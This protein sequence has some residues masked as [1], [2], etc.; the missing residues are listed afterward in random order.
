MGR[1]LLL[2]LPLLL[3]AACGDRP[4]SAEE[5]TVSEGDPSVPETEPPV[6]ETESAVAETEPAISYVTVFFS[7]GEEAVG[8]R[9]IVEEPP[10]SPG[11]EAALRELLRGP[12]PEERD[13]GL[14]SWFSPETADALRS[15]SLDEKGDVVV[16]FRDLASLIPAASSSAGSAMLLGEL[17]ATVFQHPDVRTVEYRLD[18]S[19][20]AF[21]NWLQYDC[22]ILT[23]E[24]AGFP[25]IR[26]A[27]G[28]HPLGG[29][30]QDTGTAGHVPE[31]L[32]GTV[33]GTPLLPPFWEPQ[34]SGLTTSLRGLSAVDQ[35]TAWI[36]GAGGRYAFTR[37]GGT[38]WHPGTV[39]E[40]EDL[41]FR[42]VEAFH[43]GIAY[44][45]SAGSGTGSR[46]YKTTD[47]GTTWTLQHAN[48]L[49]DAFYNGFAFWSSE[50][51]AL[52][53]DPLDG[54]LFLLL[55]EDG[56]ET[57]ERPEGS[58]LPVFRSGEYGF[59]ASG[60]NIVT[61]GREGLAVVSG[62][63]AARV[64]LSQDRGRSWEVIQTPMVAGSPSSGI[65]SIAFRSPLDAVMVG[66]DYQEDRRAGGNIARSGDGGRRWTLAAEPHGVGYRSCVAWR[67]DVLRPMW[68][69]VGTSGSSYS[70]DGG[71]SWVTIDTAA[72]NTV[73]FAG[74]VG[75]AVGPEGRVA[76]LRVD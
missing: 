69:A 17:N 39:P 23:R 14:S 2:L 42:D 45:M 72:F 30:E 65:F 27:P 53:G 9:R 61:I 13:Q 44:L 35:T 6:A 5:P 24:E 50:A 1:G 51:G 76:R 21:W 22:R 54:R 66:G 43:G 19:C 10:P 75:W 55:T 71:R 3:T 58:G 32:A 25:A 8:V 31:Q 70:E 28:A 7:R 26:L 48:E 12:T 37:D 29:P 52:V 36:S 64:F 40:A 4:P 56:G 62:G 47:W 49:E 46:I 11:L 63:S 16:D 57:W 15:V 59:A 34:T 41:D 33:P 74:P 67:E 68:V 73:A 20:E 38:T 18:G 60:T